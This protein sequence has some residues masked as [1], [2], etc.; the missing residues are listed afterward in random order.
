ML[1]PTSTPIDKQIGEFMNTFVTNSA[2][3][4]TSSV[5]VT[6]GYSFSISSAKVQTNPATDGNVLIMCAEG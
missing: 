5:S 4:S 3:V 6:P 2:F 1:P